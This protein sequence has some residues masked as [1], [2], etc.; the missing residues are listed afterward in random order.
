[1]SVVNGSSLGNDENVENGE[2]GREGAGVWLRGLE[3]AWKRGEPSQARP[4]AYAFRFTVPP[5]SIPCNLS[6]VRTPYG[7]VGK[8]TVLRSEKTMRHELNESKT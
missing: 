6:T 7:V 5:Y 3:V 8:Y 1:M 2:R 4:E